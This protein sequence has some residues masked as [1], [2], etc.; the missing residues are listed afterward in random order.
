MAAGPGGRNYGGC[1]ASS[2]A[3]QGDNGQQ[4]S[5]PGELFCV[6][7]RPGA[8]RG[9]LARVSDSAGMCAVLLGHTSQDIMGLVPQYVLACVPNSAG[10]CL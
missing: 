5:A 8:D 1:G 9:V 6:Q 3:Q 10:M 7:W 2:A 4:G